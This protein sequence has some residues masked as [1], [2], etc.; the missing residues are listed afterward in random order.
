MA[1][2]KIESSTTTNKSVVVRWTDS[3][4]LFFDRN[5]L[6]KPPVIYAGNGSPNAKELALRL[7]VS[8]TSAQVTLA[9]CAVS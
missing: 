1:K 8:R 6:R 5:N 2:A 9:G 4:C 7:I 3:L